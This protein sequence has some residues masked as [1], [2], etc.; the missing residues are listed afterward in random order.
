MNSKLLEEAIVDAEALR[1]AALKNAEQAILEKYAPEVKSAIETLLEQDE[2]MPAMAMPPMGGDISAQEDDEMD[3]PLAAT[4]GEK[5]CPGPDDDEVVVVS[6]GDLEKAI[7]DIARSNS[8]PAEEPAPMDMG[9]GMEAPMEEPAAE[10]PPAGE[11]A[12]PPEEEE[13]VPAALQEELD[14]S[15]ELIAAIL[16][17]SE[18][19]EEMVELE[20]EVVEEEK[21]PVMEAGRYEVDDKVELRRDSDLVGEAGLPPGSVGV[22]VSVGD[23]D[24]Y[25]VKFGGVEYEV[26]TW[27]LDPA[28]LKKEEGVELKQAKALQE[29]LQKKNSKLLVE[30][31]KTLNENKLLT[32]KLE[33]LIKQHNKLLEENKQVKSTALE[34]SK[35]LEQ[36]NL[37][38]AKLYYKNQA[39]GSDSLNERQKDK[40]VEAVS[41]A[42]SVDEVKMI[43]E[44]LCNAVGTFDNKGPKSLSEAV[45]KKGGLTLK[46]RQENNSNTN[47]LYN[48][49]QKIAGIKK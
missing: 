47:P 13:E 11:E 37:L 5:L 23:D 32:E 43:Y 36:S 22:V 3:V 33:S 39:L 14:I 45:E 29:S 34:L 42:G 40:I 17:E 18:E 30:R 21:E 26:R 9:M 16:A 25:N 8:V 19:L 46:P 35:H 44:T 41:K 2:P 15:E 28:Q 31:K 38:N 12:L 24:F 10:L 49:W 7:S 6:I 27:D 1:T 4:A 20:E 48:K